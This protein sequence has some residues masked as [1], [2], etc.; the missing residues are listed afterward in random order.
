MPR[1]RSVF[2][3]MGWLV[4]I[5][6][7][8][9]LFRSLYYR[10]AYE[11][12]LTCVMVL[13]LLVLG[14]VGAWKSKKLKSM[15]PGWKTPSPFTACAG[16]DTLVSG[17][18]ANIP[19]FFRLHFIVRGKFLPS[20]SNAGSSTSFKKGCSVSIETSVSRGNESA[21]LP[22]D[23]P[24]SGIFHGDGF[25]KLRDIFGFYSFACG[26]PQHRTVNV[27]C[28]PCIGKKT[29][30]NAQTGAEDQ[31][32][33]PSSDVERYYQRE[34]TPG[35]RLRDINWKSSDKIDTLIT[36]ISTDNQ[37]KVS[38]LE[39]HFRNYASVSTVLKISRENVKVEA[40]NFTLESLWLLDRA[41]ARL[42][43]FLRSLMEQ[44]SSFVFDVRSPSGSWEIEDMDDLD[45][46]FEEL[47]GISFLS[48][49]Y[50]TAIQAG[51]GDMYVFSTACDFGLKSFIQACS[52][53]PV[54]LFIVQP[55]E[56]NKQRNKTET[57]AEFLSLTDFDA[58]G[59]TLDAKW[60]TQKKLKPLGVQA[61]KTEMFYA[62][63]KI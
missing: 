61:A 56:Q 16:E 42:S 43:Y 57:E 15:E 13:F 10:N 32:N 22:I 23:F 11:I 37:E 18:S 45:A 52:P 48:P 6:S 54:T 3:P 5:F 63:L 4:L 26:A 8:L 30:I 35:D 24:M 17:L 44:N 29:P 25:C 38:R 46:F 50:E 55:E 41:K 7:L 27:R 59:A 40:G 28:S 39:V 34:Y 12:V 14:I 19:L 9:I 49:Q 58:M 36:R 62:G 33:K 53:R 1:I 60:L 47:A 20:G 31:R 2:T 21:N 51:K